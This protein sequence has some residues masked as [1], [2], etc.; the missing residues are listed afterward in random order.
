LA[1]GTAVIVPRGQWH[2]IELDATATSCPSPC[3]DGTTAG[4][5]QPDSLASDALPPR[6]FTTRTARNGTRRQRG[7]DLLSGSG[8][9]GA[10]RPFMIAVT[11][12]KMLRK[13][14]RDH[15]TGPAPAG[16]PRRAAART[17]S[18][19]AAAVTPATPAPARSAYAT[20]GY[21]KVA[22]TGPWHGAPSY[23]VMIMDITPP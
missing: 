22:Q 19:P 10:P 4:G 23:D 1:A 12:S 8:P 6:K 3:R 17:G 21:R 15:E 18:S 9:P 7:V 5:S 2:R 11:F 20:W 14:Y 16:S 13:S